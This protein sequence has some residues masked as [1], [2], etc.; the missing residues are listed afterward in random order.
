MLQ[1]RV[2]EVEKGTG[3]SKTLCCFLIP[4]GTVF[5]NGFY[6]TVE[7]S[8]WKIGTPV[9]LPNAPECVYLQNGEYLTGACSLPTATYCTKIPVSEGKLRLC[10]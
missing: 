8:P 1:K 6:E 4:P 3:F 2:E 7:I 5:K 10:I 9:D